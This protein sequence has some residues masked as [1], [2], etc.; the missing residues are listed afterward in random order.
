R[1]YAEAV[2]R[3]S[4]QRAEAA[5]DQMAKLGMKTSVLPPHERRRWVESMPNVAAQ[6]IKANPRVP[7]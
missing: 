4:M 1:L 7:A 3:V 5:L 2:G 6:W